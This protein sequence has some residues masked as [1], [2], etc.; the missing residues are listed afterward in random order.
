MAGIYQTCALMEEGSVFYWGIN[1]YG[2][3]GN[4]TTED[5]S[6]PVP[7]QFSSNGLVVRSIV[8]YLY[9]RCT[10]MNEISVFY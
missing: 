2:T 1:K 7:I 8:I 3:V 4:G 10:I 5:R 9:I 6:L